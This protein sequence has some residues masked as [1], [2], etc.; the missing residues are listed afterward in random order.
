MTEIKLECKA[1]AFF[2]E[3]AFTRQFMQ[4]KNHHHGTLSLSLSLFLFSLFLFS[5]SLP[6][7][8]V[9]D[10]GAFLMQQGPVL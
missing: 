2:G 3:D 10:P 6:L 4:F 8:I 7:I 9:Q 5:L 1:L